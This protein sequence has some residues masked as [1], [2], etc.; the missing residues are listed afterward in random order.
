MSDELFYSIFWDDPRKATYVRNS[1]MKTVKDISKYL[2]DARNR[3]SEKYEFSFSVDRIKLKLKPDRDQEDIDFDKSGFDRKVLGDFEFDKE[4]RTLLI[5]DRKPP[6][7]HIEYTDLNGNIIN[8]KIDIETRLTR[9]I[10]LEQDEIASKRFTNLLFSNSAMLQKPHKIVNYSIEGDFID[11]RGYPSDRILEVTSNTLQ[12]D[13][14]I[15]ALE[16]LIHR[17]QKQHR[18]LINLLLPIQECEWEEVRHERINCKVLDE[19]YLGGDEQKEFVEKALGSPDFSVLFGPAGSGK[20]TTILELITQAISRGEKVL[21]VASTHVAIDNILERIIEPRKNKPSLAEEYGI[22]PVRIGEEAVISEKISGYSIENKITSELSRMR[23]KLSKIKRSPAQETLYKVLKGEG[24]EVMKKM[25]IDTSN[26]VCGTT[27]GIV[28][29]PMIKENSGTFLFDL[30]IIDEASK[31]TFPE[32]LVPALYAKKWVVSGD[33][34][35][36]APYVDDE[37]IIKSLEAAAKASDLSDDMKMI[38]VNSF[39]SVSD[40]KNAQCRITVVPDDYEFFNDAAEQI[41]RIEKERQE[42]STMLIIDEPPKEKTIRLIPAARSIIVREGLFQQ[43]EDFIS[44]FSVIDNRAMA[45][46]TERQKKYLEKKLRHGAYQNNDGGWEHNIVWRMSRM[47]EMYKSGNKDKTYGYQSDID[48][49][50]PRTKG[51]NCDKIRKDIETVRIVALP[52]IMDLLKEGIESSS[53]GDDRITLFRGL[54]ESHLKERSV[55]LSYQHRMHPDISK[56]PREQIY[57]GKALLDGDGIETKRELHFNR[58]SNARSKLIDVNPPRNLNKNENPLEVERMLEELDHIMEFT[59]ADKSGKTWSVALLTFYLAQETLI[60]NELN[61]KI[62]MNKGRYFDLKASHNLEI[63][64][65]TVDRFQGHEA[66]FVILSFVR[67]RRHDKGVGFLD[68]RSRLNVAITRA[69]YAFVVL[70]D[71]PLFCRKKSLLKDFME[72]LKEDYRYR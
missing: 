14:Q 43:I 38:C 41:E 4:R 56:F 15:S 34:E 23:E 27:M 22:V 65:G 24:N 63:Q 28:N 59:R 50:M 21:L 44:P 35:Q 13:R 68:N 12:L 54:E 46:T 16:S 19:R 31:T 17:P 26:L 64:V 51:V 10:C 20:T 9:P 18:A 25:I 33:P 53:G 48:L 72:S 55:E 7:K 71:K 36:L 6:E 30:M 70:A 49:L 61:K 1:V 67:S 66:D 8:L 37:T 62:R 32:F 57:N 3:M 40:N 29:A 58:Y 2:Y 47:Y 39:E 52:S 60:R 45:E 42:R 5:K 11:I 69:R